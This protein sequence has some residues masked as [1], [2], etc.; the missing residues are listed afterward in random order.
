MSPERALSPAGLPAGLAAAAAAGSAAAHQAETARRLTTLLDGVINLLSGGCAVQLVQPSSHLVCQAC[1]A[2]G[3]WWRASGRA[4]ARIEVVTCAKCL[5][6][7]HA[8]FAVMTLQL[9]IDSCHPLFAA[10]CAAM[11]HGDASVKAR[12]C[13]REVLTGMMGLAPH[14]RLDQQVTS[15]TWVWLLS[16][17]MPAH[18]AE[19]ERRPLVPS[20]CRCARGRVGCSQTGLTALWHDV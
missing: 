15:C 1:G 6:P 4:A 11:A 16:H 19:S 20:S 3:G 14:M 12:L 5:S 13:Q 2:A 17:A 9:H 18:L 7:G 8:G 10:T